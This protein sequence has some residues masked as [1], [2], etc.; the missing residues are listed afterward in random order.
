MLCRRTKAA[1]SVWKEMRDNASTPSTVAPLPGKRKHEEDER[2]PDSTSI[3]Q[4]VSEKKQR[5]ES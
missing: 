4:E 1:L 2:L 3:V 5:Q